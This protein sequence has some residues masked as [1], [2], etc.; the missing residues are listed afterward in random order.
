MDAPLAVILAAGKGTRMKTDQPKVLVPALGRPMIHFVLDAVFK[1]GISKAVVVVGYRSDDV[2]EE[3]ADCSQVVFVE[4]TEQNG[5][6]HAVMVC[7]DQLQNHDGPTLILTGD[8]PL[9]QSSSLSRL[10]DTYRKDRPA[11]ILGTAHRDDPT[12]L[13]RIV[14][15]DSGEFLGI[16][17]EKDAT[18]AQR[19]ITEVN[20]STYVFHTPDLLSALPRLSDNNRQGEYYIT[21]CPAILKADNR[22]IRAEA[23]LEPCEALSVN[24]LEDLAAVEDEMR[25]LGYAEA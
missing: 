21:D 12:G 20:M 16:V 5:T 11:C 22:P 23:V 13:G 7:S 8:S 9:V 25:R 4:Q 17:E 15:D 14:R 10:L 19:A 18:D 2:R 1:A 6:G 3:L 24:T